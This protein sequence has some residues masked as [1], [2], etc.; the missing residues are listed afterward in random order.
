LNVAAAGL[1]QTV[2]RPF[3]D[4]PG[5][6][7]TQFL[8]AALLTDIFAVMAHQTVTFSGYAVLDLT[9]CGDLEAFLYATF[10]LQLGH[11]GLL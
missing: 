7:I 6:R 8:G 5:I 11:F 4:C 3:L 1:T 10:G 9:V 2:W